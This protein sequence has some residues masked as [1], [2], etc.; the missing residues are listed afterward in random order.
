VSTGVE[1]LG[2]RLGT[3]STLDRNCRRRGIRGEV[4]AYPPL[5]AV[6]YRPGAAAAR[7]ECRM[8]CAPYSCR[9]DHETHVVYS[10]QAWRPSIV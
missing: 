3:D 2:I 6:A 7:A 5:G 4:Q 9:Q 8:G 1:E 10:G